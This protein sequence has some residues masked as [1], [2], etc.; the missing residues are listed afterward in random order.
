MRERVL[1]MRMTSCWP[2]TSKHVC[3]LLGANLL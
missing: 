3:S 1:R 2:R